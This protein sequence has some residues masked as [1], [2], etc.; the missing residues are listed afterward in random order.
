MLPG[1]PR[2]GHGEA[3]GRGGRRK[4]KRTP[5]ADSLLRGGGG[6]GACPRGSGGLQAAP[7]LQRAQPALAAPLQLLPVLRLQLRLRRER[8]QGRRGS[9][10]PRAPRLPRPAPG[11]TRGLE[12]AARVAD[13]RGTAACRRRSA[14]CSILR[15]SS[16]T[17]SSWDRGSGAAAFFS[18]NL[19]GDRAGLRRRAVRTGEWERLLRGT[20][21][22]RTAPVGSPPAPLPLCCWHLGKAF[23]VREPGARLR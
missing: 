12:R 1:N 9:G 15:C 8:E 10:R 22:P 23:R 11:L 6:P 14:A 20:G 5:L 18:S 4:R 16:S 7:L 3:G 17:R 2:S 21:P 13:T 19:G